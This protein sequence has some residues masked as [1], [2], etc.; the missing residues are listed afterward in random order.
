MN[1]RGLSWALVC[2][3][4]GAAVPTP[5]QQPP[6]RDMR[7]MPIL[8]SVPGMERARVEKNVVFS[9]AGGEE[10]KADVYMPEKPGTYPVVLLVSGGSVNDWRE[11]EFYTQMG[12]M[13]AAQGMVGVSYD[14]RFPRIADSVIGA[15]ED[16]L[17]L[18]E[19]MKKNA[20]KYGADPGRVCTWH[21]SAGGRLAGS[22][23][24]EGAPVHCVALTYAV[25]SLGEG[26]ADPKLAPYSALNQVKQRGSKFPPVLVVRAGRDAKVLNDS[27]EAFVREALTQNAPLTL[28]NYP[29][30]DHG[31][32]VLNDTEET[33]RVLRQSFEW[34]REH[35]RR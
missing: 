10:L 22:M 34:L 9:R 2:L 27:I 3:L 16:T 19:H 13:L 23:L 14:K 1:P 33:R 15:H 4:A 31:F 17:A 18:I 6:A 30:G 25:L 29:S 5:G 28:I 24:Q 8:Y 12:R 35:T 32:E 7:R 21:F 20:Q 11:A 26:D